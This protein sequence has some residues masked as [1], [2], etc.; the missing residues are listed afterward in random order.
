MLQDDLRSKEIQLQNLDQQFEHEVSLKDQKINQQESYINEL[1]TQIQNSQETLNSNLELE[2][3]R[4]KEE[5][6][7]INCKVDEL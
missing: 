5:K 3:E 2:R 7:Q 4:F 6:K 1:K